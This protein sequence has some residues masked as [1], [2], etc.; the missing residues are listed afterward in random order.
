MKIKG[1]K[2]LRLA[3]GQ[4]TNWRLINDSSQEEEEFLR[5]AQGTIARFKIRFKLNIWTN[6]I[7]RNLLN[8]G[9]TSQRKWQG[10]PSRR[11]GNGVKHRV[12]QKPKHLH[13]QYSNTVVVSI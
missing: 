6:H 10:N 11:L 8:Y 7:M 9:K 5:V 2:S 1:T 12:H 13:H 4:L 3:E